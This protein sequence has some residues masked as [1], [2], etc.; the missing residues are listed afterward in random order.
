MEAL[1]AEFL[2]YFQDRKIA[3][4]KYTFFILRMDFNTMMI[5]WLSDWLI[6]TFFYWQFHSTFVFQNYLKIIFKMPNQ[7]F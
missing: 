2:Y 1:T 4:L 7:Y 5:H 3:Y 6:L